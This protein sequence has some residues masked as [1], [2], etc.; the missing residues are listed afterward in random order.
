MADGHRYRPTNVFLT[1]SESARNVHRRGPISFRDLIHSTANQ[2]LM[3]QPQRFLYSWSPAA[4]AMR[5]MT[6]RINSQ[7]TAIAAANP[8]PRRL[9]GRAVP[10]WIPD[11]ALRVN[12]VGKWCQ[13]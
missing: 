7:W 2:R 11:G 10:L 8:H 1:S 3:G 9:N 5:S 4:I 12:G 13:D 6:F